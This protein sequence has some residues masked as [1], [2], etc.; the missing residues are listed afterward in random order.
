MYNSVSILDGSPGQDCD[1][2]VVGEREAGILVAA[3]HHHG[4]RGEDAG[5]RVPRPARA[6]LET[7]RIKY[8][9]ERLSGEDIRLAGKPR[10]GE[11]P[12]LNHLLMRLL[13]F[14]QLEVGHHFLLHYFGLLHLLSLGQVALQ[15]HHRLHDVVV[16]FRTE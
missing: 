2:V 16:G 8:P 12:H 3:V 10:E 5:Q 11:L 1:H 9:A 13:Q 15:P 6:Q 14:V 4:R 7:V